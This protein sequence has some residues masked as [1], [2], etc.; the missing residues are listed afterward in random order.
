MN[1]TWSDSASTVKSATMSSSAHL[2]C[3]KCSSA[4]TRPAPTISEAA[5]ATGSKFLRVAIATRTTCGEAPRMHHWKP[6]DVGGGQRRVPEDTVLDDDDQLVVAPRPTHHVES[7]E[8]T[9]L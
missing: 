2:R 5:E 7:T 6:K 9:E 4:L 1:G 8:Q 3:C